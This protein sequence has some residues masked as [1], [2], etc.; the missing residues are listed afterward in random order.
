MKYAIVENG[1]VVNIAVADD[2]VADNWIEA[3][4]AEIGDLWDGQGF[5]KPA[6]TPEEI[7]AELLATR[8][9]LNIVFMS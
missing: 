5:S 1:V 3:N 2:P 9:V 7:E 4:G 6:K 8:H